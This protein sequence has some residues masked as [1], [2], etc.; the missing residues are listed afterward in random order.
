MLTAR[1]QRE[2]GAP[3]E[4]AGGPAADLSL[5]MLPKVGRLLDPLPDSPLR[6]LE[7]TVHKTNSGKVRPL[8]RISSSRSH[9]ASRDQL[10]VTE[11][12]ETE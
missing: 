9:D 2:L 7:Q 10:W 8:P 5:E 6:R 12:K 1:L 3:L 4:R 11:E